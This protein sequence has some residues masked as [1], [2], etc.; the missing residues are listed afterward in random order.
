VVAALLLLS[1]GAS[2]EDVM[3]EYLLSKSSVGA[4]PDSLTAVLDEIEQ[5][6]GAEA[7]LNDIG[8]DS[9]ALEALRGRAVVT[10]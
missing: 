3:Q 9:G 5:R 4:Y 10:E 8:I 7:V 6:G 2:R 1:L